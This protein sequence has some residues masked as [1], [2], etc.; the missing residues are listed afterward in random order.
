MREAG[1]GRGTGEEQI[2]FLSFSLRNS[3]RLL[4][5]GWMRGEGEEEWTDGGGG[6]GGRVIAADHGLQKRLKNNLYKC[7]R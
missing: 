1:R 6:R 3:G 2:G 7:E 4:E 5:E